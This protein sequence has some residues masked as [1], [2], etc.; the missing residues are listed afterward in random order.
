MRRIELRRKP[1]ETVLVAIKHGFLNIFFTE[2]NEYKERDKI[3][4][5]SDVVVEK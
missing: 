1:R 5:L 2:Y 3:T 4:K